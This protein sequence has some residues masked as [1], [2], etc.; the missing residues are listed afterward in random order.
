MLSEYTQQADENCEKAGTLDERT[1]D[2]GDKLVLARTLRLAST[3]LK[4]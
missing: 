2:D 4:G 3:G 1:A